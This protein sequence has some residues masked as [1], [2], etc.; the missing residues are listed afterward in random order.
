MQIN[1]TIREWTIISRLI[2]TA[3][4]ERLFDNP[5]HFYYVDDCEMEI[6]KNRIDSNLNSCMSSCSM[7]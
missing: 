1:L 4:K 7:D 2:E 3:V 6:V 5:A